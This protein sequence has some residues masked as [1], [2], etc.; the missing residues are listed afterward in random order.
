MHKAANVT[1][2][3]PKLFVKKPKSDLHDIRMAETWK[4]TKAAFDGFVET[5]QV[6][7][8]RAAAKLVKDRDELLTFLD[9]PAGHWQHIRTTYPVKSVFSTVRYRARKT[10]GC[11]QPQCGPHHGLQADDIR[12]GETATHLG[13]KPSAGGDR[14]S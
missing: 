13:A 6:K 9:F 5:Y 14:G 10:G 7:Q 12:H 11:A 2:A 8:E 4:E 3:M 1:G